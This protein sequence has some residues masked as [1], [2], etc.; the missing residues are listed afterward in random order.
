MKGVAT[1]A[2]D[3]GEIYEAEIHPFEAHGVG[4]RDWKIKK[5]LN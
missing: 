4:R 5:R 1:V 2:D 3:S